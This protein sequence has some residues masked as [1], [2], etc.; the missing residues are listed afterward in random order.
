ME[1][2]LIPAENGHPARASD[3]GLQ[4][5]RLSRMTIAELRVKYREVFGEDIHV[6]HKP[7]LIRRIG[8]QLQAQAQGDLSERARRRIAEIADQAD[9]GKDA[10][11]RVSTGQPSAPV[12]RSLTQVGAQRD[13]CLPPPGTLLRRRHQGREIVVKVLEDGFECDSQRYGSLSALARELT[14]TRWNG[15]LFFGLAERRHG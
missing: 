9:L 2:W 3:A 6:L 10:P 8:W 13:P 7:F 4:I 11:S 5:R 15:L 14:G 12:R 1:V